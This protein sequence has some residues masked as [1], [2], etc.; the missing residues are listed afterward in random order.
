MLFEREAAPE[1]AA[2][3]ARAALQHLPIAYGG[4]TSTSSHSEAKER[5]QQQ[6]QQHNLGGRGGG[7]VGEGAEGMSIDPSPPKLSSGGVTGQ[8]GGVRASS[9]QQMLHLTGGVEGIARGGVRKQ[10]RQQLRVREARL[11]SN[12]FKVGV[13]VGGWVSLW[14]WV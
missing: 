14:V 2:I 5:Q 3:F 12:I 10:R 4:S 9:Q 8:K 13:C 7:G 11:W 1:G 6:Q